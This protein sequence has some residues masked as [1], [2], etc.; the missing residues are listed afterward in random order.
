P[1]CGRTIGGKFEILTSRLR[2][3]CASTLGYG[4]PVSELMPSGYCDGPIVVGV[5]VGVGVSLGGG[6]AVGVKD[7]VGVCVAAACAGVLVAKGAGRGVFVPGSSGCPP[8]C[9]ETGSAAENAANVSVN[10]NKRDRLRIESPCLDCTK[11][12]PGAGANRKYKH[13]IPHCTG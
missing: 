10:R 8:N 2:R 5:N 13:L 6:V 11:T 7:G 4:S 12:T 1:L 9:P 3:S